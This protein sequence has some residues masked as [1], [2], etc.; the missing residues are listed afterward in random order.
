[1]RIQFAALE[2]REA[3]HIVDQ[4]PGDAH[5][6]GLVVAVESVEG[7]TLSERADLLGNL[8]SLLGRKLL[9]GLFEKRPHVEHVDHMRDVLGAVHMV[10]E[11]ALHLP[12]RGPVVAAVDDLCQE[13][14]VG[15]AVD[16]F[17]LFV[18]VGHHEDVLVSAH[19]PSQGEA[20]NRKV[21]FVIPTRDEDP[22]IVA[23]TIEGLMATTGASWREIIVVD[24]GSVEPVMATGPG[25]TVIR[26]TEPTGVSRA[27]L[28]GSE[29]STGDVLVWL[30]AHMTFGADWL[31]RMLAE[32]DSG[33]LLCAPWQ[34]YARDRTHCWGSDFG[35]GEQRDHARGLSPGFRFAP[36]T[37]ARRR[38][39][40]SVPMVIGACYMATRSTYERIGGICPLLRTYG[41][42]EVDLSARAWLTGRGVR[43]VT[44]ANVG[45]LDR[46]SFPYPVSF[47]DIEFNQIV[48]I[49]SLFEEGTASLLE[50]FLLPISDNVRQR[51]A[52]T[53]IEGWRAR[54]QKNRR[55]SDAD[56]FRR[57]AP[58]V[59][60]AFREAPR[61]RRGHLPSNYLQAMLV[62]EPRPNP[63]G[64]VTDIG[65]S[66]PPRRP[67]EPTLYTIRASVVS[68][69]GV[70][71]VLPG[72]DNSGRHGLV[73]ELV[74]AGGVIYSDAR[75]M[76]DAEGKAHPDYESEPDFVVRPPIPVGLIAAVELSARRTW[77]ISPISA[78]QA[79]LHLIANA[80][81]DP[82]EGL[83]QAV[84]RAA[85][86]ALAFKGR[87]GPARPVARCLLRKIVQAA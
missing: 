74:R 24:D 30:D 44:P 7:D 66:S 20:V 36:M 17:H 61:I 77:R 25:I 52:C 28:L 87:R 5:L 43:C 78:A 18:D 73:A 42:D 85:A 54:V 57:I 64:K 37:V 15:L 75:A 84:D 40:P 2:A 70:A 53:D 71:L 56:F 19:A 32:V 10:V 83:F 68:W 72:D 79:A 65:N 47:D 11:D 3:L 4:E 12:P 63:L 39:V 13:F 1:M 38:A 41:G 27:R 58:N 34:N 46:S 9:V 45:H 51:L 82:A 80:V 16:E 69:K 48:T 55:M 59:P 29:A 60:I 8:L 23:A 81:G 76:L 49:R 31:E 22:L 26:N 86:H 33:A 50:A 21:S 67:S 6:A 35:W 14:W 62:A